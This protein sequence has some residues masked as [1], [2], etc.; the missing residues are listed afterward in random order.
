MSTAQPHPPAPRSYHRP[1]VGSAGSGLC[2]HWWFFYLGEV[3]GC[4]AAPFEEEQG[5]VVGGGPAFELQ[6]V[7]EQ[8]DRLLDR[9]SF[10][11]DAFDAVSEA[12]LAELRA[13]L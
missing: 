12:P 1:M 5:R 13:A 10:A 6:R 7:G 8:A 2:R 11:F 9:G 3:V 4:A